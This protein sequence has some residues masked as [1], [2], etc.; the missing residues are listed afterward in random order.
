[1]HKTHVDMG[2]DITEYIYNIY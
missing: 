2:M 1:M